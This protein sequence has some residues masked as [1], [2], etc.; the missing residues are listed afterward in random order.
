MFF[1]FSESQSSAIATVGVNGQDVAIS[2]RSNPDKVYNFVTEN[3]DQLVEFLQNP[4][5][6]SIGQMYH[7]WVNENI[8]IPVEELAAV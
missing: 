8:L 2:F 1:Q 6:Q 7:R 4:G 3:E 5:D